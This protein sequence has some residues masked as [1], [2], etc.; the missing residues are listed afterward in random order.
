MSAANHFSEVLVRGAVFAHG[1]EALV[2]RVSARPAFPGSSGK[3]RAFS[4]QFRTVH[5]PVA[6]A[7]WIS[8]ISWAVERGPSRRRRC[9][10][11]TL[12]PA[13]GGVIGTDIDLLVGVVLAQQLFSWNWVDGI[14]LPSRV[15]DAVDGICCLTDYDLSTVIDMG[16]GEGVPSLALVGD[17]DLV[18]DG[19]DA[20]VSTCRTAGLAVTGARPCSQCAHRSGSMSPSKP[21]QLVL[22]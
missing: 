15:F 10:P 19:V 9:G 14:S 3:G 12:Y 17:G 20:A 13:R 11:G 16:L 5:Q 6:A 4:T 8:P 22:L 18:G 7:A 21:L 1:G 2:S